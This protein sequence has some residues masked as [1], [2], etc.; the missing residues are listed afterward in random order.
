M[1]G[2]A[3]RISGVLVE[4]FGLKCDPVI[5]KPRSMKKQT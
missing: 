3:G 2:D 1:D 5:I 4:N